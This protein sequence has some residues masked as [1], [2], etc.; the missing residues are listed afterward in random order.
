MNHQIGIVGLGRMGGN[1]VLH[2]LEGGIDVVAYNRSRGKVDDLIVEAAALPKNDPLGKLTPAYDIETFVSSLKAP[3]IVWLMIPNGT[4]IDDML[5]QLISFGIEKGDIVI[6]GGNT[7]Y[8]DTVR[9][10]GEMQKMG[11]QYIDCGTSG[12]LEGARHGACLMIGGDEATVHSLEWLWNA[13]AVK[14]GWA[15]FG[16][17]G[18]GNFV[19]MV[20]NGVEYGMNEAI[21]EGFDI[22]SKGPYKLDFAKV[23]HNWTHGSVVRSWLVELLAKTLDSDPKLDSFSGK[24]GGGETGKWTREAASEFGVADPVIE[25]SIKAREKSMEKPTFAGKVVSA[26]RAGYGGHKEPK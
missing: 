17:S 9:R 20:H 6:D 11:I 1:M 5:K 16:P 22:L 23:A 24:V 26:L 4:P 21:G 13:F 3:R 15:Y 25:E 10:N 12:G 8:K 14:E 18:A 19:K 2:A 7:Y